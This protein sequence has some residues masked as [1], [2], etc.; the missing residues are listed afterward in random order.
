M[1]FMFEQI[2]RNSYMNLFFARTIPKPAQ[3]TPFASINIPPKRE[4]LI[5]SAHFLP[6]SCASI[7]NDGDA[8]RMHCMF[9]DAYNNQL[10][11]EITMKT[12]LYLNKS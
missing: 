3:F 7:L 5:I 1:E 10:S 2:F 6:L 8:L 4:L 9:T 12:S 11:D